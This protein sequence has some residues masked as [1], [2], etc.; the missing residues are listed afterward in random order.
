M[1]ELV[2]TRLMQNPLGQIAPA[3]HRG[4]I[5]RV[6]D[7]AATVYLLPAEFDALDDEQLRAKLSQAPYRALADT[8]VT[9]P[10]KSARAAQP[11]L[12]RTPAPATAARGQKDNLGSLTGPRRAGRPAQP[13]W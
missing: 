1:A 12:A 11:P 10:T 13:L 9:I 3:G 5:I 2:I 6:S 4:D 7:G 8:A